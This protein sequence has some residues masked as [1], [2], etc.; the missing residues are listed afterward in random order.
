M[1]FWPQPHQ[2]H[3]TATKKA[4][5]GRVMLAT[6]TYPTVN[7]LGQAFRGLNSPSRPFS[8]TYSPECLEGKFCEVGL[9]FCGVLRSSARG[10]G[11]PQR[12]EGY[13]VLLLPPLP[14]E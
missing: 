14:Y 11:T 5:T 13:V 10:G 6:M 4:P 1:L 7:N 2:M 12:K 9:P 3:R 8:C